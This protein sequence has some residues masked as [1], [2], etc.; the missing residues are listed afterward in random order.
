MLAYEVLGASGGCR[1]DSAPTLLCLHGNSSHRGIWRPV[2]AELRDFRRILLDLRGHGDSEPVDPPAYNP[3]DHAADVA[4]VV[5]ALGLETYAILA[6]SA[7]ALAAARFISDTGPG[8]MAPAPVAF[9]WVD[10]DPLVPRTQ[11]EYFHQGAASVA[12]V[13]PTVEDALR[14]FRRMYPNVAE[15]RLRSFVTGG[16]RQVEEGWR[17]KL[18]PRTYATWEPGDLRP[19]L[20]RVTCPTLVLHGAESR[21]SSPEG[22]TALQRGLPHATLRGIPGGS[23]LLLLEHPDRVAAAIGDFIAEAFTSGRPAPGA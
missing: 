11:V 14:G 17:L 4:R 12:R 8:A 5:A 21:V 9:V 7:G 23:H 10:I 20:P 1:P 3:P 13:F 6:H 22:L 16:L 2:A 18:D 15:D 19:A